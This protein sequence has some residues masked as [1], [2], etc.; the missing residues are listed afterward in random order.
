MDP[1]HGRPFCKIILLKFHNYDDDDDDDNNDNNNNNNNTVEP[2]SANGQNY[3][4]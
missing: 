1:K 2:A 3:P 4:Q